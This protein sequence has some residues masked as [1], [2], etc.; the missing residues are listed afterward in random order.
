MHYIRVIYS[1]LSARLLNQN[2]AYI[3]GVQNLLWRLTTRSGTRSDGMSAACTQKADERACRSITSAHRR[4]L[5][6]AAAGLVALSLMTE[7]NIM[8]CTPVNVA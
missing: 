5:W 8:Y 2:L 3:H 1:G 7:Q 6:V 4:V